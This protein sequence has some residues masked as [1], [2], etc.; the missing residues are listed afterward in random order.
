[1]IEIVDWVGRITTIL[2]IIAVIGGAVAWARGVL[3]ALWRLG[4]GLAK[5]KIAI[6]A[7]GDNFSSLEGLLTDS[8]LFKSNNIVRISGTNDLGK[9]DYASLFLLYWPDWKEDIERIL[10]SKKDAT[11]LIVYAP[12]GSGIIP[13]A[14]MD[15][16]A[17]HRNVIVTNVRGRLLNDIVVS[18]MTTEYKN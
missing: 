14:Q 5:R 15:S 12:Q 3:P 18:M 7:K 9:G 1:M 11:T 8:K 10:S 17:E 2:F 13:K 16:L 4:N 6:Y